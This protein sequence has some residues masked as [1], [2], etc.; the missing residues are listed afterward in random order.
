MNMSQNRLMYLLITSLILGVVPQ[1]LAEDAV[2]PDKNL[3]GL[4]REILKQKQIEK[5]YTRLSFTIPNLIDESVPIGEDGSANKEIRKWG[6]IPQFDF[7]IHNHIDLSENLD[8]D[9]KLT[10]II[11]FCMK[12]CNTF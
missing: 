8:L 6:S 11:I 4:I 9:P 3:E 5:E 12:N 1:I 7:N 10:K 2:F